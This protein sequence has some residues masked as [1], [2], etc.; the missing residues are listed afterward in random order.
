MAS[1]SDPCVLVVEDETAQLELVAYNFEKEG[2]RVVRAGDGE[3]GLLCAQEEQPD[4]IILDWMLPKVSGIEVCRQLKRQNRTKRIP[5]LMLTARGEEADR[6]RGLD[7]GADDYVV[8][9]YSVNELLA[10]ARAMLRRTRPGSVGET[11]SY[12]D[13]TL[14]AEQ[15][16]VQRGGQSVKLGPTE[17]RLLSVLIER[18]GRVWTREQLLDRVWGNEAEVDLRTVDVHV[19]RLRKALHIVDARDPV[20]TVRGTGYSLDYDG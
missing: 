4:L 9:P 16:K 6:V 19:G 10:R 3:E 14:D 15:H 7:T 2:F 1:P 12:D 20:R 18:P 11:L 13:I 5:V 8:K 17:F